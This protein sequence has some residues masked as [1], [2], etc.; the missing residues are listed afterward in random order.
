MAAVGAAPFMWGGRGGLAWIM[1]LSCSHFL[2]SLKMRSM[3]SERSTLR[4]V[5]LP[6]AEDIEMPM[7]MNEMTTTTQSNTFIRF[8]K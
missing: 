7:S 8:A 5:E 2:A 6:L 3:R 1:L 4:L